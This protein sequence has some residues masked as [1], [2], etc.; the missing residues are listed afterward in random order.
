MNKNGII[1]IAVVAILAVSGA[2]AFFVINDNDDEVEKKGLYRLDPAVSNVNMGQCSATPG[3]I[4]T[5]EQMYKDYYGA[6]EDDSLT[7]AQAKAD[8]TFWNEYCKWDSIITSKDD[9]TYDVNIYTKAKG[10]AVVNIP[11]CDTVVSMGTM[12]IETM[13]FLA[14][15]KNNV[16]VYSPESLENDGVRNYMSTTI[17]GGMI[18]SYFNDEAPF[19]LSLVPESG[20]FDL[21]VTS[22]QKSR[23][24]N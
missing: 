18:Y 19:M 7:I 17:S 11:V 16:A 10:N 2:A 24:K 8:T 15:A 13:Y 12:Y 23:M 20:Y 22:V 3:V 6:L 5:I 9:G 4:I 14:C 21:G 1:A